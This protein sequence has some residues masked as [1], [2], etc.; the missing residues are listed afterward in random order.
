MGFCCMTLC[1]IRILL[2]LLQ[3][4]LLE[5]Q[6]ES[7]T[8]CDRNVMSLSSWLDVQQDRLRKDR[9]A[10]SQTAIGK[11]LTDCQVT[12]IPTPTIAL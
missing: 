8:E 7:W 11:A 12:E 2:I 6:L 3:I 5:T 4:L 9:E 10:C 1:L